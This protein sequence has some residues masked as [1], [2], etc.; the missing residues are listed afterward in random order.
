MPR[1]TGTLA[2]L[3]GSAALF[4]GVELLVPVI[5]VT[6]GLGLVTAL[7]GLVSLLVHLAGLLL[8][9][10]GCLA[11][12]AGGL[13]ALD[14]YGEA[15]AGYAILFGIVA[16]IGWLLGVG[17]TQLFGPWVGDVL[18]AVGQA[19]T[20]LLGLLLVVVLLALLVTMVVVAYGVT[21][22]PVVL[23]LER[24]ATVY[25]DELDAGGIAPLAWLVPPAVALAGV[26]VHG[27][28][29]GTAGHLAVVVLGCLAVS[30][31]LRSALYIRGRTTGATARR[32]R[33]VTGLPSLLL[34]TGAL[35][36]GADRV[37]PQAVA[38]LEPAF[39]T[40]YTGAALLAPY[41]AGPA[42]P[43]VAVLTLTLVAAGGVL[44][45]DEAYERLTGT[46]QATGQRG[47]PQRG[48]SSGAST[49]ETGTDTGARGWSDQTG[50]TE[51][52]WV[53]DDGDTELV[54]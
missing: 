41:P 42:H 17:A 27:W 47:A 6:V 46:T 39:A 43:V 16:A 35:S 21:A 20:L 28:V 54:D 52:A 11:L 14:A 38:G 26:A 36:W 12:L 22:G 3:G 31:P 7:G 9:I 34:A 33:V 32:R 29:T 1:A 40:A 48:G 24:V 53:D 5:V 44:A 45:A 10:G 15:L 2:G 51:P 19:A 13:A 50:D 25:L 4:V 8:V 18:D 49:T 37:A 23:L 30:V